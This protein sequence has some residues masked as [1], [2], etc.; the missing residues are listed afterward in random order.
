MEIK[1]GGE[2][3]RV[4]RSEYQIRVWAR[5]AAKG[6]LQAAEQ[7]LDTHHLSKTRGDYRHVVVEIEE[8]ERPTRKVKLDRSMSAI[9][10]AARYKKLLDELEGS[11]PD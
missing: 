8:W 11:W 3:K 1:E 2:K 4:S 9:E 10:A 7:L 6:D 5:Q